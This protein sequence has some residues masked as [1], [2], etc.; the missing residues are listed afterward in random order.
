M[1]PEST[2][3]GQK[4]KKVRTDAGL[5]QEQFA[6]KLFVSR[7]AVTKWESDRGLPDIENLKAIA[8]LFDVSVDTLLKDEEFSLTPVVESITLTDFHKGG[9]AKNPY[10]AVVLAKYPQATQI[11]ELVRQHRGSFKET[12]IELATNSG[13]IFGLGNQF[14]DTSHNYFVVLPSRV[15]F[16]RVTKERVEARDYTGRTDKQTFV[17]G[18]SRYHKGR[19]F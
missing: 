6:E 14:T 1:S 16:V 2:T 5:T 9:R 12:L 15:L 3:L 7:Q 8:G 13:G 10:D 19:T 11:I 18:P 4:I 17:F